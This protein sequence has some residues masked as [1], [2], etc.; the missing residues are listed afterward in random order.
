MHQKGLQMDP[1][2]MTDF[3]KL[4]EQKRKLF[5]SRMEDLQVTSE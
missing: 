4:R 5:N 3:E 2:F 1:E